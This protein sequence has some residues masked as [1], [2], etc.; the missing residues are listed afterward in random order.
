MPWNLKRRRSMA[1]SREVGNRED[2]LCSVNRQSERTSRAFSLLFQSWVHV[3]SQAVVGA[4]R[5]MADTLED[6][7]DL[8]CDPRSGSN[9]KG[10]NQNQ[11]KSGPDE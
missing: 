10:K 6:L 1:R 7:N 3:G 8:Y 2:T 4:A 9:D 5:I 11:R